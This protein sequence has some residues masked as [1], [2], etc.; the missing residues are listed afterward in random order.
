MAKKFFS[1]ITVTLN[2]K[3]DLLSTIHCLKNQS[4]KNFEYIVIDGGS[5]DGTLEVIKQNLNIINQWQSEKDNG[6]Y[7]AM[8]KGIDLCQGEFIGMINAGDKYT[9]NGLSIIFN[10][11]KNHKVDFIFG[12]VMKKVLRYGFRRFRIYWNFDFYSSHSS[13]FFIRRSSQNKLGKYKLKYKISSDYDLFY[14]M[15]VKEKMLGIS[16]KKDEIIGYFK[17]GTSYSSKFTF[18]EHLNEETQIRLDN[19]QNLLSILIV[20]TIHYF[21]NFKKIDKNNRI[22]YFINSI[23]NII[24]KNIVN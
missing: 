3:E 6:I 23:L 13:G 1:L 24:N 2:C 7:D 17:S 12:T 16:T 20:Y 8:N 18:V 11:L 15:I 19:N 4:F 10:Y 9:S 21:K 22:R 14:R 5:T